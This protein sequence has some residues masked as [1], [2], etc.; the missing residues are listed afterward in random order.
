MCSIAAAISAA[1][2]GVCRG[3]LRSKPHALISGSMV[4]SNAPSVAFPTSMA[5]ATTA[6]SAAD[7]A[8]GSVLACV[9]KR[10]ISLPGR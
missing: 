5:L 2:S 7:T 9:L 8:N 6:M 10:E 1:D 3:P 4:T